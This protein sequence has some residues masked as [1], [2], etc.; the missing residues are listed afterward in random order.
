[1]IQPHAEI[2]F[3]GTAVN[4][5]LWPRQAEHTVCPKKSE[6]INILQ[7]QPQICSDLNKILHKTTSVTNITT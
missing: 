5:R 1:M 2:Q 3:S 4:S 6:P 7:Q